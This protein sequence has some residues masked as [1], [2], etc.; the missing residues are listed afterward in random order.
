MNEGREEEGGVDGG[1]LVSVR[2]ERVGGDGRGG[3]GGLG[4]GEV[5]YRGGDWQEERRID[6]KWK[7]E[8]R[9]G[10]EGDEERKSVLTET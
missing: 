3:R 8:G 6:G 5:S 4:G 9:G 2:K 7:K 10:D 1:S